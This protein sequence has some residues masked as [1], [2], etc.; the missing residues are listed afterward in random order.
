MNDLAISNK[1]S[2]KEPFTF[3]VG[4]MVR[5]HYEITEGDKTRIQP[6]EGLV[7]ARRGKQTSKTFTVRRIAVDQ[8]GVERIFPLFSPKIKKVEVLR[9]GKVR[10]AKLY[11]LRD[12]IG[13]AALYV[14]PATS[15]ASPVTKKAASVKKPAAAKTK[16]LPKSAAKKTPAAVKVKEDNSGKAKKD[17]PTAKTPTAEKG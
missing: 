9:Q 4:D 5:V 13:K 7:I 12:R 3:R 8:I 16:S 1:A 14:K 2:L 15:K 10:R 17:Q 6:Y 11:Y